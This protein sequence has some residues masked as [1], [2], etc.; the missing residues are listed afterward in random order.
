MDRY[1]QFLA[2]TLEI[3]QFPGDSRK[4][5]EEFL[6]NAQKETYVDLVLTLPEEEQTTLQKRLF[7][8]P[9]G[10]TPEYVLEEY[11]SPLDVSIALQENIMESYKQFVQNVINILP[12]DKQKQL[13][14]FLMPLV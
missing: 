5:I 13:Q 10:K 8:P 7:Y 2:K 1:K 3:M 12:P 14:D 6:Q 11:F 4:W 9:F